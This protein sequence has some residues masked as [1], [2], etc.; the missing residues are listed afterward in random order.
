[1]VFQEV[2][3]RFGPRLGCGRMNASGS[4]PRRRVRD[5]IR[6]PKAAVAV[7]LALL[8]ATPV[9]YVL[10][11]TAPSTTVPQAR[12][13]PDESPFPA[14]P[15]ASVLHVVL[16]GPNVNESTRL[17][18]LSLQGIVNREAV[19]LYLD[20]ENESA[21]PT[22]ILAYLQSRYAV[23]A[24][25]VTIDWALDRYLARAAGLV[26]YDPQR[27]ESVNIATTY[28][29]IHDA[30][31]AGPDTAENLSSW[32][33]K[34]ILLDYAASDWTSLDAVGAYDRAL[35]ELYPQCD[36]DLLSILPPE[37]DALRDYIVATRTFVFYDNQ[38]LLATPQEIASTLRILHAAPRGIPILG[39]FRSP[40]LTEENAFLQ[41][42]SSEGKFVVGTEE[43][44]NLSVLTAFG[45]TSTFSQPAPAS[46]AL[47]VQD[48]VYAVVAVA[49][50][51]SLD[52]VGHRMREMWADPA[53]GTIPV[54]WSLNPL[55]T[56]LAPPY[57]DYYYQSA[58][59]QDRFIAGPSG[60]GY[61]YPDFTRPGDLSA[62]LQFS[63]RYLQKADM[64]VAWILSAFTA[65][66]IPHSSAS[67][68]EYVDWLS[69]RGIALDYDDQPT[70][71]DYWMQSG[72]TGASPTIRSTQLWTSK[73]NFLAK[74][75]AALS[76]RKP[77]PYFLWM[78]VYP[79]RFDLADA[80]E[81]LADLANR[82]GIGVEVV[83]PEQLFALM[84]QDFHD[85]AS[86]DLASMEADPITPRLL[87]GYLDSA[88]LHLARAAEAGQA[89]DVQ[90]SAL[91]AFLASETLRDAMLLEDII[92]VLAAGLVILG[93]G[94]VRPLWKPVRAGRLRPEMWGLVAGTVIVAL[95]LLDFRAVLR[96]NFW[97]YGYLFVGIA[98]A[99][100]ATPLRAFLDKSYPARAGRVALILFV[101]ASL[102]TFWTSAGF[103]L[104][105][106]T[107]TLSLQ[108]VLR[109]RPRATRS[110]VLSVLA[111]T[112]LGYWL[113]VTLFVFAGLF[114]VLL[115]AAL[116]APCV[117]RAPGEGT[118]TR[119]GAWSL[120]FA[121]V[122][123]L[124]ALSAF[125]SFSVGLR[126][127]LQDENLATLGVALLAIVPVIAFPLTTL[128][129]RGSERSFGLRALLVAALFSAGMLLVSASVTATLML[130]GATTAFAL[131][132]WSFL[133]DYAAR[134]GA[135]ERI[136][137][138]LFS[139]IP[140]LALFIRLPPVAYSLAIGP[141]PWVL[142]Y[143]LYAL[144][145]LWAV[146]AL[147]F[148][149]AKALHGRSS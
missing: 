80:K 86:D 76:A 117:H 99:G 56:E 20:F 15:P 42:A 26:V 28:A 17:T 144:P 8:F 25:T 96:D 41:L 61:M 113:S 100:F 110:F 51:D 33:D 43:V 23:A 5:S 135:L 47:P 82:T 81:V 64:D 112:A 149:G 71:T 133:Q 32:I 128:V 142:E 11:W 68:S 52:F 59:P 50:G 78:T 70:A 29:G 10:W 7:T 36:H 6:S 57:V 107:G 45:R 49:D 75:Q 115:A 73:D 44:P 48:K 140:L 19:E 24:D 114:A 12:F 98:V 13:N 129:R 3:C 9:L 1:M 77:S 35:A 136:A 89:G 121:L 2:T 124:I 27:P 125:H 39:W 74:V 67:L 148:A 104:A 38:G 69:P 123:P 145:V 91:E 14:F 58:T 21:D 116:L 4:S 120:A 22:S 31:I 84:I 102:F 126:L 88:R 139:L 106:L 34:P 131:A 62:Y 40:T 143:A 134:G 87:P 92:V 53:R 122:L 101:V 16:A 137:A 60:A 85:R 97:T 130:L 90:R 79:W 109:D 127:E 147:A 72:T 103:P 55:L 119:K 138:P 105:T 66:E 18:L 83:T 108:I 65:S 46:P 37:E 95:F 146:A 111:G 141:L 132:A 94:M 63:K 93:V 30:V 118:R 54:A